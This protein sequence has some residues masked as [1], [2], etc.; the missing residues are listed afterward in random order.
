[1]C[2]DLQCCLRITKQR[3]LCIQGVAKRKFP[4]AQS[5]R[6][7]LYNCVR[8][9]VIDPHRRSTHLALMSRCQNLDRFRELRTCFLCSLF[10]FGERALMWRI[11]Y[12]KRD[13]ALH[14]CP[15]MTMRHMKNMT[16]TFDLILTRGLIGFVNTAV[17]FVV[18][19][20]SSR[21]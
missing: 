8:S 7:S 1:M 3:N 5:F 10:V 12:T 14:F 20:W 15:R 17:D 11:S 16:T 6:P 2:S 19:T 21:W 4:R 13:I 9:P 18:G